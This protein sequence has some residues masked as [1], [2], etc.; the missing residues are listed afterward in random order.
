[1]F[2][3][4][5]FIVQRSVYYTVQC[6]VFNVECSVYIV[7]YEVFSVQCSVQI[8]IVFLFPIPPHAAAASRPFLNSAHTP[9]H[10]STHLF[11]PCG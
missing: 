8:V 1:M 2:D 3:L 5:L 6:S 11:G 10:P 7:E 9:I 4:Y